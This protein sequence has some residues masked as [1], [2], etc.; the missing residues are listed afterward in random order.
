VE[1]RLI[2]GNSYLSHPLTKVW[3]VTT[4]PREVSEGFV[5]DADDAYA[6]GLWCADSY[7][8]S[9]S[10]G[11]TNVEPDLILWFGRYLAKTLSPDRVRLR[12]YE[13][14]GNGIDEQVLRLTDRVSVRPPFKMKRTAYQVYVNCR[15]LVRRFFEGRRRL[16]EL[17]SKWV[18]PYIAG[19]FDGDGSFGTRTRIA[20]TTE[21]EA[22]LDSQLLRAAGIE[23]SS[24]LY[25]SKANEFCVYIYGSDV[26]LFINLI[27]PYSWRGIASPLR[28]CNGI[29]Q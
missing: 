16:S 15:P 10:I 20:Y 26:E 5:Y 14:P 28:D 18:G 23:N 3:R 4:I 8:W 25:Y 6:V 9:S 29:A 2:S 7:W 21:V 11:L 22:Q 17:D 24:V 1:N 13:V 12:V 27:K 19:R